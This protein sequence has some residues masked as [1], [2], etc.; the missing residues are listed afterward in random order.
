MKHVL[1]LSILCLF[2]IVACSSD[3]SGAPSQTSVAMWQDEFTVRDAWLRER[4]PEES[5]VYIRVPNL[6][7][8]LTTPKGNAL[9]AALRSEVN[10]RNVQAIHTGLVENLFPMFPAFDEAS[11]RLIAARLR[12]PVEV[13]FRFAP[14]PG[15]LAVANLNVA[16]TDSFVEELE[17]AGF[18]LAGPLDS[19][20]VAEVEGL[21]MPAFLKFDQGS[22][23]LVLNVGAGVSRERFVQTLESLDNKRE[24]RIRNAEAKIDDSGQGFF[25]WIDADNAMGPIRMMVPPEQL[26]PLTDMGIDS[27]SSAAF[28]WGVANGK[29]RMAVVADLKADE[30]RGLI[31][32]VVNTKGAVS[33]GAP[34]GLMTLS[35]PTAEEF[36]RLEAAILAMTDSKE[37]N[38]WPEAKA[39]FADFMGVTIEELLGAIGPEVSV[40][41]DS[42][43]DYVAVR[44][45]DPKIWDKFAATVFEKSGSDAAGFKR[46]GQSFY[47]WK[48]PGLPG[49]DDKADDSSAWYLQLLSRPKEHIYWTR[50]GDFLYFASVPQPLFDRAA[51]TERTDVAGWLTNTQ[52]IDPENAVLTISGT[53]QKLPRRLYSMYIDILNLLADVGQADIDIWNMPSAGDLNLPVMG[54]VGLS[55]ELGDP[56]VAAV[57]TFESNPFE[58]LGGG[59]ASSIAAVGI[60]AAIAVP[61]YQ[62]YTV[63]AKVVS[64]VVLSG[65]L[66]TQVA[67]YY[68]ATGKFPDGE[69]ADAMRVTDIPHDYIESIVL[70]SA[71]G[72]VV[73]EYNEA[74]GYGGMVIFEPTDTEFGYLDWNCS[75]TLDE[76]YLPSVCR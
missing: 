36:T 4:L 28:G 76:T 64:G 70:E 20:G 27:V 58:M 46:H 37:D 62:D 45:R 39:Q 48:L 71:T 19:D 17:G 13:A 44:L 75:S 8:L 55:I 65:P 3:K 32:R 42:V 25:A 34:D 1:V 18:A 72:K 50:E 35:I 24:H 26:Q 60:L 38:S 51:A 10:V 14:A 53:S 52:K 40:V 15:A 21:P 54:T 43:G 66:R 56:T 6:L 33:V 23:L 41:L 5:M 9:D 61:A 73:I 68:A 7:G 74:V 29:A 30:D 59:G 63:R 31:P 11:F 16:D 67:E 49:L 22:G 12:S 69:D 2:L 57:M 47:H